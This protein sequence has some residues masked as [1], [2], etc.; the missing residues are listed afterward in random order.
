M[1]PALLRRR[2]SV[3][4]SAA[5][6][7]ALTSSALT[8]NSAPASAE[9]DAVATTVADAAS[10]STEIEASAIATQHG[11][12]VLVEDS[13]T[14]TSQ[15]MANADGTFT[16]ETAGAPVRTLD[17]SGEWTEIDLDLQ[18]VDG[19]LE[20][21]AS[22]A[23]VSLSDGAGQEALAA[24]ERDGESLGMDWLGELPTPTVDGNKATYRLDDTTDLVVTAL[25]AGF[26]VHVVL[27]A[28]PT[29]APTYRLPLLLDDLDA[30]Q[31]DDGSLRLTDDAGDTVARAH[32]FK[33][34][35][36]TR[37]EAGD[38]ARIVPVDTDLVERTDGSSELRLKPDLGFLT[39]PDTLYPVVV[40]PDVATITAPRL[41][42]TF[43][44]TGNT[45]QQG[46]HYMLKVGWDSNNSSESYSF[47]QFDHAG[48][49]GKKVLAATMTVRQYWAATCSA[50]TLVTRVPNASWLAGGGGAMVWANRPG[51]VDNDAY[52][53]LKDFNHGITGCGDA[54]ESINVQ[55]I[56]SAWASGSLPNFGFR[57]SVPGGSS[58]DSSYQ[59]RFCSADSDSNTTSRDHCLTLAEEPM[60]HVTYAQP[61]NAP[62]NV[63]GVLSA[64]GTTSTMTWAAPAVTGGLPITR[65]RILRTP[66]SV[67]TVTNSASTSHVLSG[68]AP[69]TAYEFKVRAETAAGIGPYSTAVW[70]TPSA[71]VVTSTFYPSGSPVLDTSDD[72]NPNFHWT[73]PSGTSSFEISKDGGP[74]TPVASGGASLSWYPTAGTH[75]F[76]VYALGPA[77]TSSS[78]GSFS[79]SV[80]SANTP[81]TPTMLQTAEQ[82]TGSPILSGV[83]G[84]DSQGE[85]RARFRV[86]NIGGAEVDGS[87]F[88]VHVMAGNRASY[89]LE[90]GV[91]I[92]GTY[93]SWTLQACRGADDCSTASSNQPMI[94]TDPTG[95]GPVV[96]ST[97]IPASGLTDRILNVA[98]DGCGSSACT[99]VT[100]SDL[101]IG[102][103]GSGGV[104]RSLLHIDTTSIPMGSTITAATL[105]L[106]SAIALGSATPS[107]IETKILPVAWSDNTPAQDIIAPQGGDISASPVEV[108]EAVDVDVSYVMQ[109]WL[110]G[111]A[112]NNG[113]MIRATDEGKT[114]WF[115]ASTHSA[116]PSRRPSVDVSFVPPA[117]PEPPRSLRSEDADTGFVVSWASPIS[118][119]Y[120]GSTT[121]YEVITKDSTGAVVDTRTTAGTSANV[122]GLPNGV[123]YAVEVRSKTPHGTSAPA[124]T[125]ASTAAVAAASDFV[126]AV[127]SYFSARNVV[128]VGGANTSAS[129]LSGLSQAARV[130]GRLT[131][132]LPSLIADR[133]L[134]EAHQGGQRSTS[135]VHL[136]DS[137]VSGAGD[138][139]DVRG[140]ASFSETL[141]TG[142]PNGES[143]TTESSRPFMA[144]FRPCA[145]SYCMAEVYDLD[146]VNWVVDHATYSEPTLLGSDTEGFSALLATPDTDA[147]EQG[148]DGW[149]VHGGQ[150]PSE[151]PFQT[152]GKFYKLPSSIGTRQWAIDHYT[153]KKMYQGN[154]TNFVSRAMHWGGRMAFRS[155][156]ANVMSDSAWWR[157]AGTLGTFPQVF[158]RQSRTW[159]NAEHHSY[160][161]GMLP[162]TFR[163]YYNQAQVGDIV[164]YKF[165][166]SN[167]INHASVVTKVDGVGGVWVT[168]SD[169]A[170]RD[171]SLHQQISELKA[172]S[173]D[174]APTIW[175]RRIG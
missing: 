150:A 44:Y 109:E 20:P 100:G 15:T 12:A 89:R 140:V 130:S 69:S 18:Q 173:D 53:V 155:F 156:N 132:E 172:G 99:P 73:T 34:W 26:A 61:P 84:G 62:T 106:S 112:P 122:T 143:T 42:D 38:P 162:G 138:R 1:R 25:R 80:V 76:T 21:S 19:R 102:G 145:D 74:R 98:P 88:D 60:L 55:P 129:A 97:T 27:H 49:S 22:P 108:G 147:I 124:T 6:S 8:V 47:I 133:E 36:A 78:G 160:F 125:S 126:T 134:L 51:Y 110:S 104:W 57:L 175:I 79:F 39:H 167:R 107:G 54:T 128:R 87:P 40:D 86:W 159:I 103:D 93:Y 161:T 83:V 119:N 63:K 82:D 153:E 85:L 141:S 75:T 10:A 152:V 165:P 92:P 66:G 166:N 7:I 41:R 46:Q 4:V 72:P 158:P 50:R 13:V 30:R 127:T 142:S 33:M 170:H 58:A 117:A 169:A 2:S 31:L 164:Y 149:P 77:G 14:E 116:D 174:R 105:R 94:V 144:S 131:A 90:P 163:R 43:V 118:L 3:L 151:V 171:K 111:E 16:V 91:L 56:A 136:T 96:T 81:G 45:V 168:Q 148:A 35:D 137:V 9:P 113:L 11:H 114:G 70:S 135:A 121:S 115:T 28:P 48:F 123:T 157:N 67:E 95:A 52:R 59:K 5:L 17:D 120:S 101:K 64:S 154:C 146:A 29:S 68:L 32:Q 71:P 23:V 24:V 65:Y 139:I 37:D